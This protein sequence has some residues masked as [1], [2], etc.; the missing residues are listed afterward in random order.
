MDVAL[1]EPALGEP[2]LGDLGD[3]GDLTFKLV[4]YLVSRTR[5]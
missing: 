2:D 4:V 5:L 3:L 1:G